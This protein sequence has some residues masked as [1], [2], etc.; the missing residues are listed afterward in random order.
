[1]YG[2]LSC[3]DRVIISGNVQPLCYAKG[4]TGYLYA[5]HIRIFDYA[6]TFAEP[7]RE[8]V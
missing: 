6:K 3:Y 7:L 5:H 4:M 2:T 1:M 8:L